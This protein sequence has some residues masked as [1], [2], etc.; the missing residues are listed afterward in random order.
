MNASEDTIVSIANWHNAAAA[1]FARGLSKSEISVELN[2][3]LNQVNHLFAQKTF[4]DLVSQK[5]RKNGDVFAFL[6]GLV[7]DSL[8]AV[9]KIR[10]DENVAPAVRLKAA[11]SLLDR[12][13]G[14]P[15]KNAKQITT[16]ETKVGADAVD[17]LRQLDEELERE[18]QRAAV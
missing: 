3:P 18:K 2:K 1:M 13:I 10:D 4:A 6:D 12:S 14:T 16:R 11:D 5:I 17:E 7:V 9:I 8:L 15:A